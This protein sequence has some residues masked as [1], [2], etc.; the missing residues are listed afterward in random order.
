MTPAPLLEELLWLTRADC[1][2]RNKRKAEALGRRID[3]LEVRIADLRAREELASIRP[4]L[5]GRE[6]MDHLGMPPGP[7]VGDALAHLLEIRLDEGP[8][9]HDEALVARRWWATT[10][11]G[12]P[13]SHPDSMSPRTAGHLDTASNDPDTTRSTWTWAGIVVGVDGSEHSLDALRWAAEEARLRNQPPHRGRHVHDADP[14]HGSTRWPSP[15][16][17]TSR[18]RRRRCWV[19]PSTSVREY[20]RP[21]RRRGVLRGDRGPRR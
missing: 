1:T 14:G 12:G 5:D 21:G 4:D 18:P 13:P 16:R 8:L 2:T 20:R 17:P 3:D 19:P 7:V 10:I 11:V 15:T 9:D 6:I